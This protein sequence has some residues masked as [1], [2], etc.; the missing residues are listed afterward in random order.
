MERQ[1]FRLDDYGW[2]CYVYYVVREL[3][4]EEILDMLIE[5]GCRGED[6]YKA[7]DNLKSGK[8]DTGLT[9]SNKDARETVIVLAKTSTPLEFAQS[10]QHEIGHCA[11]HIAQ[12]L[13]I[14]PHGEEVRYIGDSIVEKTWD[15][16]KHLLCEHCRGKHDM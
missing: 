13:G 5:I 1:E 7:H 3:N 10:W 14:N 9:Y 6:L 11:D 15:I 16:S 8:C 4:A 12:C 2:T